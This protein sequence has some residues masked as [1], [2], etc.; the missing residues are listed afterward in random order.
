M[1]RISSA[2]KL[3]MEALESIILTRHVEDDIDSI[4]INLKRKLEDL[5]YITFTEDD[6]MIHSALI[7]EFPD[8]PDRRRK[9]D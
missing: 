7:D 8:D 6:N 1:A 2:T 3:C 9:H 5:D 4:L